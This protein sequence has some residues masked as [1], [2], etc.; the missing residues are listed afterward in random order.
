MGDA[1]GGSTDLAMRGRSTIGSKA[2]VFAPLIVLSAL[3]GCFAALF[4][5][6]HRA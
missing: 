2:L 5:F 6:V 3:F 1:R 4:I